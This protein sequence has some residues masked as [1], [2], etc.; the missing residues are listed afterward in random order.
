V[1]EEKIRHILAGKITGNGG[2]NIFAT[3]RAKMP[4][5]EKKAKKLRFAAKATITFA[6]NILS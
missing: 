4:E 3:G 2:K 6:E 5:R 1:Q